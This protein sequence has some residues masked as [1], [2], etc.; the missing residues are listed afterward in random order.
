MLSVLF[1]ISEP[2]ELHSRREHMRYALIFGAEIDKKR[3]WIVEK[4]EI[5]H[6]FVNKIMLHY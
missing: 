2:D 4:G 1:F 5:L 6:L 3:A